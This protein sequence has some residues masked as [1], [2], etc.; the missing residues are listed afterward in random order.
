MPDEVADD[1]TPYRLFV[2][3]RP[4][5]TPLGVCTLHTFVLVLCVLPS[6]IQRRESICMSSSFSHLGTTLCTSQAQAHVRVVAPVA[7]TLMV[8]YTRARSLSPPLSLSLSSLSPLSHSHL[9]ACLLDRFTSLSY[10]ICALCLSQ[11]SNRRG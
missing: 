11:L 1:L 3:P 9:Y 10:T 2:H 4:A 7:H 5:P 6:G 8:T